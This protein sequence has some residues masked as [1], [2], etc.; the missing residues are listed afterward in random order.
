MELT[1]K[2]KESP[3]AALKSR[4]NNFEP[5]QDLELPFAP[6]SENRISYTHGLVE[7]RGFKFLVFPVTFVFWE[8][9][10]QGSKIHT[11]DTNIFSFPSRW[12]WPGEHIS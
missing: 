6:Y 3:T 4:D 8:E 7:C 5:Q 2:R 11:R 9:E 1:L 10:D 12:R